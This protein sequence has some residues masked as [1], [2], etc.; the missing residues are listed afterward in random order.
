[1]TCSCASRGVCSKLPTAPTPALLTQISIRPWPNSAAWV[2]SACTWSLRV[3]SV[4]IAT[5]SVPQSVHSSSTS[6]NAC[7]S[8]AA[9]TS[10]APLQAKACA[11]A[12]PIPL[13]APVMTTTLPRNGPFPGAGASGS[14]DCE[15]CSMLPAVGRRVSLAAI[16]ESCSAVPSTSTSFMPSMVPATRS[17]KTGSP[18]A[19]RLS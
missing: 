14:S 18:C 1:M 19:S 17:G 15:A 11:A 6:N 9:S 7:S 4:M 2:A 8:R 13:D 10:R 5:A 12:L 3:T 16:F